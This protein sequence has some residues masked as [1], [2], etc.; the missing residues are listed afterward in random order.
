MSTDAFWSTPTKEL[1]TELGSSDNGLT[2]AA[3]AAQLAKL[4]KARAHNS[5]WRFVGLFLGQ[6]KSPIILILL[7][8]A[9]VSA[10]LGD[11]TSA[12]IIIAIVVASGT[13]G[14][15]QEFHAADAV[16]KLLALVQITANIVRDG[17][18]SEI[19]VAQVVPGDVFLLHAG[20][21]I[22]AD[23]LLIEST[24]L[25]VNEAVLTGEPFP[26]E[27]T[28]GVLAV[29]TQLGQRTN[30]VFLGT[31]VVSGTAKAIIVHIG[32]ETEF[33][34]VSQSLAHRPSETEFER[35]VRRFGLLLMEVTMVLVLAMFAANV[36]FHRPVIE[37][38]LFSLAIAVGLTPQLLPAIIS[39]NLAAGARR[40][41]EKKVIVKVLA[42]IENFGS[43]DV[44]CSDKTGTL[45]DG[46]VR[47]HDGVG[48]DGKSNDRVKLYGYLNAFN[49]TGYSNPIDAAIC[50]AAKTD[51]KGYAKVREQP[52]DFVRK[53]LTIILKKDGHY[54]AISKGAVSNILDVC[55]TVEKADGSASPIKTELAGIGKEFESVSKDGNRA[56]GVAYRDFGTTAPVGDC[57]AE[58][59][60]LGMLL[61]FDPLR[62]EIT[63][64]LQDLRNLGVSVKF[65]TGDNRF[66]AAALLKQAGVPNAKVLSG[67]EMLKLT[68]EA[69]RRVVGSV[70]IFAEVE[71]NQ[72]ARIVV[73]LQKAGHVVGHLGDGINDA[74]AIHAAD[75][76][77]SVSNA[78]DVAK[79]AADIVLMEKDLGVLKDGIREGRVTFANTLKYVFMATSANF[80]NMFSMAGASLF[81]KFLPML[82]T[83]ILLTNFMTDLPE[84]TI[85]TDNVDPE[86]I[87]QP[88]RWDIG[89][90]TRFMIV[91]GLANSMCDYITFA[92]LLFFLHSTEIQFQTGWFIENVVTAALIVLVVRTRRPFYK[93]KPSRAL[94]IA[95]L[96]SVAA[97][98]V[99]PVTPAARFLHLEPLPLSFL[100]MLA[101]LLVLYVVVAETA[102][103]YFYRGS[104]THRH[105]E[106]KSSR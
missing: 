82:P 29:E 21:L 43:M 88:H 69:F 48:Y 52:Y 32:K 37:S 70:D 46:T 24:D 61:F 22:P 55:T 9:V 94:F 96:A 68:D 23:S 85:A 7:F 20:D 101:G 89:F 98:V 38:L 41:A 79:D 77:I 53:R 12:F 92:F 54:I 83:Q 8:A 25:F 78:V 16:Q 28:V 19:P 31:N 58:M 26:I 56:I 44:L 62:P 57:E 64:T 51:I 39:V 33:G 6:F 36:Y 63:G 81:L 97:V 3:A 90:I 15:W 106:H 2:A 93:S 91:F 76:G 102:K 40:M 60:F 95:T 47:L 87:D 65:V 45:T 105:G 59:T 13:L 18:P 103:F 42:S 35:G 86:W 5:R 66:V 73:A 4:P 74:S 49:Q 67:P 80:G 84:M 100:A 71:P 104:R 99:I 14:F 17:K 11:Q 1:F 30:C 34:K 72:K 27:K 75:V 50:D 10:A